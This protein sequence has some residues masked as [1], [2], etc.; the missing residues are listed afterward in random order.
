MAER[1]RWVLLSYRIPREPSTPRI[2]VWR[3]LRQL[4]AAQVVDGLVALPAD[5]RTREQF[6]W[7]AEAVREA[8]GEA[9][10]WE[11]SLTSAA[12]ERALMANM[13]RSVSDE[14][15]ELIALAR[16]ARGDDPSS[17]RRTLAR[18]R[19]RLR[20]VAARDYFGSLDKEPALKAIERLGAGVEVNA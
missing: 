3:K 7:L 5:R 12:Q 20:G 9:W 1:R 16:R 2:S 13:N 6:E 4:G 15:K 17:R 18:L 19:R 11:S 8:A 14:Y 10:V